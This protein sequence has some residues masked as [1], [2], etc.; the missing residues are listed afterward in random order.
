MK[1]IGNFLIS[2][3]LIGLV[4]GLGIWRL[5]FDRSAPA[6]NGQQRAAMVD[7]VPT[8]ELAAGTKLSVAPGTPGAAAPA[9]SA[10]APASSAAAFTLAFVSTTAIKLDGTAAAGTSADPLRLRKPDGGFELKPDATKQQALQLRSNGVAFDVAAADASDMRFGPTDGA[11]YE[12]VLDQPKDITTA[13][14]SKPMLASG[15]RGQV[16]V[17]GAMAVQTLQPLLVKAD[18]GN[19]P[20]VLHPIRVSGQPGLSDIA[21]EINQPGLRVDDGSVKL[22]ACA[23][24]ANSNKWQQAGVSSTR[25]GDAGNAKLLIALPPGAFPVS[26]DWHHAVSVAVLSSDGRY[27]AVGSFTAVSRPWAAAAAT[28]IVVVLLGSLMLLRGRQLTTDAAG[29]RPW[30]SGLFIGADG[31]PSLSLWQ[32]FVWTVITVWGLLYVFIVAGSLLTLTPEMMGLLG[33]A[34]TGSVLARW[35]ATSSG[36]TSRLP[37]STGAAAVGGV[38]ATPAPPRQHLFWQMLSSNGSF[39]L[40]KLQLFIF[41][42]LIA[43][44]VVGRIADAAAFPTLDIN[45]LLLMGVSQGVYITG[46]AVGAGTV[47]RAQALKAQ[48]DVGAEQMAN[49][50][51]ALAL[52]EAEKKQLDADIAKQSAAAG[53]VVDPA[54]GARLAVLA[55]EMADLTRRLAAAQTQQDTLKNDFNK[56][57]AELGLVIKP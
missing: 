31:D 29:N 28:L 47:A 52:R 50:R 3:A 55:D 19:A 9:A 38:G 17:R 49:L 15:A 21:V 41:T 43:M 57:V 4:L 27:A 35:I 33:I 32:T 11:T 20:A 7:C 16:V 14:G 56:A 12:V 5:D 44:Y 54:L 26:G 36:S 22:T 25:G 46:K 18:T 42:M 53:A 39:D 40:L 10:A 48:F 1:D 24:L 34:G 2:T 6:V 45:T 8:T 23:W 30:F 13:T 51:G 37:A